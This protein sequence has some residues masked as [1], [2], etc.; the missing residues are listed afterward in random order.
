MKAYDLLRNLQ[1]GEEAA[2]NEVRLADY[3][4]KT[5]TFDLFV[6]GDHDLYLG[7]KG[8]GKSAIARYVTDPKVPIP[9]LS[10]VLIIPAFNIEDSPLFESLATD[11]FEV[12]EDLLRV[13]FT[14]YIIGLVGNRLVELDSRVDR[15]VLARLLED[16]GLRTGRAEMRTV[17]DRVVEWARRLLPKRLSTSVRVDPSGQP[18]VTG[19]IDFRLPDDDDAEPDEG[20]VGVA[21]PRFASTILTAILRESIKVLG[22]LRRRCWI[23]FDRLDE[24][25]AVDRDLERIAL[26]GLLRAHMNICSYG[27]KVRPKLFLR[28]DLYDR[29]TEKSDFVNASHIRSTV[30]DWDGD[31]L[32]DLIFQRVAG[33]AELRRIFSLPATV[34]NDRKR[35]AQLMKLLPPTM[36]GRNTITWMFAVTTD[37]SEQLNPRNVL[38]LL[39]EARQHAMQTAR[40][41]D[42]AFETFKALLPA[43]AL[44]EGRRK[45]SEAR[46]RNNIYAEFNG[47]RPLVE[48]LRG[49]LG[50]F[51]RRRLATLLDLPDSAEL[52]NAIEDLV[53]AGVLRRQA[54]DVYVIAE[55]FKPAMHVATTE[56]ASDGPPTRSSKATGPAAIPVK[57]LSS[58]AKKVGPPRSSI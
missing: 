43:T 49:P 42:E 38:A 5:T 20:R 54:G 19:T 48:R 1:L 33:N 34:N 22:E 45:L 41:N 18:V 51:T 14:G 29:I 7:R 4:I 47:L 9:E 37:G 32:T 10:D 31:S 23:V 50:N 28:S 56:P 15:S 44:A 26:R 52:T 6:D 21:P 11:L 27:H 8:S 57:K 17:W 39:R 53:Y 55:L 24:A 30:L 2:E 40:R 3:F 58:P 13:L 46:L 25:F 12:S 16:A 36:D 35:R